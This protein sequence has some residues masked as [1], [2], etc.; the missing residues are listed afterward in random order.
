MY[1]RWQVEI[2]EKDAAEMKLQEQL[3]KLHIGISTNFERLSNILDAMQ[4]QLMSGGKSKNIA[5]DDPTLG[6]PPPILGFGSNMNTILTDSCSVQV[7]NPLPKL[8]FPKFN[9]FHPR[10]WMLKCNE[11]FKLVPN[12]SDEQKIVLA[13]KYFEGKAALWY[14]SFSSKHVVVN[15]NQLMEVISARFE[16][17]RKAKIVEEFNQLKHTGNYMDYVGRFVELKKC[18]LMF[19]EGI[20]TESYFME[21]F[22]SGLSDD[23]RAAINM[24]A[25]TSLEQ[26]MKLGKNHLIAMEVSTKMIKGNNRYVPNSAS[27]NDDRSTIKKFPSAST[28]SNRGPLPLTT[29]IKSHAECH[30]TSQHFWYKMM[31]TK[32]KRGAEGIFVMTMQKP[33]YEENQG[34]NMLI[35][36]IEK[37]VKELLDFWG[38]IG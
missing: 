19:G 16:D 31:N 26:I 35:L 17:I 29:L 15:W 9:G 1:Q 3:T 21:N 27:Q 33:T 6:D 36:E 22:L 37:S 20:F 13:S 10:A 24:F 25:P 5:D 23:V 11:Y 12:I 28:C 2:R 14:Q 8:E 34:L 32:A 30:F 38:G 4:L 7:N 18:M